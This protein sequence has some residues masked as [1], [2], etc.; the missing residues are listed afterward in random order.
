MKLILTIAALAALTG[1][2]TTPPSPLRTTPVFF[3]PWSAALDANALSAIAIAAQTAQAE[4]Q[5]RVEVTGAADSVGGDKANR[6]I[7]EARAQMVADQLETDGVAPG[8]IAVR[9]AGVVHDLA[10]IGTPSQFA[11]RVLI[12]IGG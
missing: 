4:P 3:Q 5:A 1:C 7:S 8:R 12:V 10:P 9:G 2:A 6:Y 11:R